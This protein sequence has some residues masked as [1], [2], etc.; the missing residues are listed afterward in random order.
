MMSV[1]GFKIKK[2]VCDEVCLIR[3]PGKNLDK[4]W[5]KMKKLQ[6][7]KLIWEMLKEKILF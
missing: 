2:N 6:E 1:N 3:E 4:F 5:D 7:V